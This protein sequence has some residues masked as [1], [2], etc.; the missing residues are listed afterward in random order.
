MTVTHPAVTPADALF[1]AA[2][3]AGYAPSIH[4]TQPWRW[5]L[6]GD[7][8]DLYADRSRVLAVTDP[9]ARMATLSCGTALHHARAVLAA[10]GCHV[11]VE[12][13]PEPA[14]PDHLARL[15]IDGPAPAAPD[16]I[17]LAD[18]IRERHT[19]RRPATGVPVRQSSLRAITAAVEAQGT[20]LHLLRAEQVYDLAAATGHAQ[21]AETADPAWDSE[22]ARWTGSGRPPEAGVPDAA[23]P[24]TA[25]QTTVPGRDFGHRGALSGTAGHD[26][27]AIFGVLYGPGDGRIDWLRAGEALSAAWL[28]ATGLGVS[29]LPMSA[30][31]EVDGTR[32]AVRRLIADLGH[33]YLALRLGTANPDEAGAR[34]TPRLSTDQTIDRT[35]A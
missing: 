8:L 3:A 27:A 23:I 28:T 20:R 6:T 11:I 14:G 13:L 12:R 4:N 2:S 19:D 33:P 10:L 34:H 7:V 30:A 18:T 32:E 16:T 15:R 9:D 1:A 35:P 24:R 31:V 21:D 25:P 26:E 5:R 17:R 22:L 29:L